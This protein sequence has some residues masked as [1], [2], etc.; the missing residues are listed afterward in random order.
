MIQDAAQKTPDGKF[1][2][3]NTGK[4]IDGKFHYGHKY[5]HEHRRLKADDTGGHPS[6]PTWSG[7]R[8]GVK[9]ENGQAIISCSVTNSNC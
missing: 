4:V 8:T 1:I 2:D 6:L 5:G 7:N 3:P 9:T